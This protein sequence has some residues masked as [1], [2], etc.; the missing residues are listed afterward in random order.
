MVYNSPNLKLNQQSE[1]QQWGI[2]KNGGGRNAI[3]LRV[4]PTV[5]NVSRAGVK[6]HHAAFQ[7]LM[8]Q[9]SSIFERTDKT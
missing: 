6:I 7:P 3:T 4:T 1:K 9:I 5:Q 2:H 8:M